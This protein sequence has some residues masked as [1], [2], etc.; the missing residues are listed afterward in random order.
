[1]DQ[2]PC[3]V[4]CQDLASSR[5]S[6]LLLTCRASI[7]TP[8]G[9]RSKF[10]YDPESGLFELAGVLP[11]GMAFPLSFGFIPATK[12]EDGDPVDILV[13]AD[14]ICPLAAS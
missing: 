14:E 5:S 10:D 9:L 8:R 6:C 12:A 2:R 7:E 4:S 3:A 1:L 11:A 13:L